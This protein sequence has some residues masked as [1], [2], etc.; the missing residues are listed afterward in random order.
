MT[1]L[2]PFSEIPIDAG[3]ILSVIAGKRPQRPD[4]DALIEPISDELWSVIE[5]CWAHEAEKRPEMSS[6]VKKLTKMCGA[7]RPLRL[8]SI[9]D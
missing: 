2:H 3:V 9:G 7:Q 8:L 6:V 4:D 5:E 1:G